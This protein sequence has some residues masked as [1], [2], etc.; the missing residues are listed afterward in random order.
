MQ[1]ATNM[2]HHVAVRVQTIDSS[3]TG[4][5]LG[6]EVRLRPINRPYDGRASSLQ[7]ANDYCRYRIVAED[8]LRRC[9]GAAARA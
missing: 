6:Y 3:L 2:Y 9:A 5:G 1:G 4:V 7:D 8:D